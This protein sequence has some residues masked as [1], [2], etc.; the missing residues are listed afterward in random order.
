MGETKVI[1]LCGSRMAMQVLQNLV[2]FKQLVAVVIPVSCKEFALEVQGLLKESGIPVVTVTKKN[3]STKLQQIIKKYDAALGLIVTFPY[4]LPASVYM[5][6]EKGFFNFHPGPLPAYQGP[7]P[8]FQQIKNREEYAGG[9]IHKVDDDFDT[10]Q[11]ILSERIRLSVDD[12]HGTLITKLAGLAAGMIDVLIKMAGFGITIPSRPQNLKKAVYYKRQSAPDITINWHTM[13]AD[14]IIA[15]VNACNPWNKGAV[16]KCNQKI[17]RILQAEKTE[18]AN[19]MT[20]TDPG[21]I[22]AIEK[23]GVIV[24]TNSHVQL[25][26]RLIYIDEGFLSAARLNELGFF[27][28]NRFENL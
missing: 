25:K 14:T 24:S 19:T 7:D 9:T 6:P 11:L 15:L 12:T 20:A 10:G 22:L 23:D 3:Y 27:A 26:V 28:G 17:I 18:P 2:F 8:M 4:K 16:T 21:M 13:N 5:L 1:L